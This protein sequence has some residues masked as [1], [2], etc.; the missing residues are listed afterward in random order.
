MSTLDPIVAK[1]MSQ[2]HDKYSVVPADKT[3]NNIVF[4][5]V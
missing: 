3:P 4:M 2:L 1:H 5:C